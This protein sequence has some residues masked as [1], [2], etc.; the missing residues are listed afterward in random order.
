MEMV[1]RP[2]GFTEPHTLTDITSQITLF[3]TI[4]GLLFEHGSFHTAHLLHSVCQ[5]YNNSFS[6]RWIGRGGPVAWPTRS[7]DLKPREFCLWG[8][9]KSVVFAEPVPDAQALEQRV[10]VDCDAIRVQAMNIRKS[11]AIHDATYTQHDK[12]TARRFSDLRIEPMAHLAPGLAYIRPITPLYAPLANGMMGLC[13]RPRRVSPEAQPLR[14]HPMFLGMTRSWGLEWKRRVELTTCRFSLSVLRCW[15]LVV[16]TSLRS[17]SAENAIGRSRS[18]TCPVEAGVDEPFCCVIVL[19]WPVLHEWT[20]EWS[21][22]NAQAQHVELGLCDL[23]RIGCSRFI[24]TWEILN[25]S[26]DCVSV[27][28]H[29]A[30]LTRG[31]LSS[32]AGE[33]KSVYFHVET[34]ADVAVGK[35]VFSVLPRFL[36]RC[37]PSLFHFHLVSLSLVLDTQSVRLCQISLLAS[38]QDEPGLIPGRVTPGFSHVE[39]VPDDVAGWRVF[40]GISRFP[41]PFIPALL[42]THFND[43]HWLS[44]LSC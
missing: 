13:G 4:L 25:P 10:R 19:V 32:I 11:G 16:G 39:I 3:E 9:L 44:G 40:S 37:I 2:R 7:P 20:C 43:R 1:E 29:T 12:K 38:H 14:P 34:V 36:H 31:E 22:G 15:F 42:H 33:V 8:H 26:W 24:R 23:F 27:F 30:R 5:H 41:S 18:K 21:R 6:G 28:E 35:W 17:T